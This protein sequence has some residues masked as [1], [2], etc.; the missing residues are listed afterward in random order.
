[1]N[2][3]FYG[4]CLTILQQEIEPASVGLIYMDPPFNSKRN[5][6]AI[7]KDATGR[8]LPDQVEAFCDMFTCDEECE[9]RIREM[10]VFL[11]KRGISNESVEVLMSLMKALRRTAQG[12]LAY[13]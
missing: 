2:K 13:L 1:M 6:N 4:D 8:S 7:Y 3:L 11:H 12:L 5:Y 10:P 9:R